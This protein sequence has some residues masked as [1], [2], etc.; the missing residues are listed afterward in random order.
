MP[1]GLLAAAFLAVRVQ[2]GGGVEIAGAMLRC[3]KR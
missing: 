1:Y 2:G 3:G